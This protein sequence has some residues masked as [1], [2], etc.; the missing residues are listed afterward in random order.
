MK[1]VIYFVIL[2]LIANFA[3]ANA[4][5]RL[6]Q[7]IV[8][9]S[10][11]IS[12]VLKEIGLQS[13]KKLLGISSYHKFFKGF[14]GKKIDGGIYLPS[15]VF[16]EI[17]KD[18]ILFSDESID[19][20]RTLKKAR[21]SFENFKKIIE[22]KSRGKD[23]F[24]FSK[25]VFSLI[26][27]IVSNCQLELK[28]LV[29]KVNKIQEE[30]LNFKL[31]R[32]QSHYFSLSGSRKLSPEKEYLIT[33]DLFVKSLKEIKNFNTYESNLNYTSIPQKKISMLPKVQWWRVKQDRSEL[34]I[35]LKKDW[36]LLH[37]DSVL[38]PG[39]SQVYII[40]KLLGFLRTF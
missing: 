19:G 15:K 23:S 11:P 4:N 12:F 21:E 7:N 14:K 39:L 26:E 38:V 10:G 13:D 37:G 24:T 32:K 22:V 33:N 31:N 5:C 34:G 3:K 27:T 18:Y 29:Q 17:K 2:S 1:D 16:Y 6:N 40:E 28:N 25:E 30:L 8:S 35:E 9:L 36:I 20:M